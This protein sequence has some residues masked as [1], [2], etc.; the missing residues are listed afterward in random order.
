MPNPPD[1][2]CDLKCARAKPRREEAA[3]YAAYSAVYAYSVHAV[4][5]PSAFEPEHLAQCE[6]LRRLAR[7]SGLAARDV[8][9]GP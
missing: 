6:L 2:Y 8:G 5:D 9:S 3:A 4:T 7:P 1:F